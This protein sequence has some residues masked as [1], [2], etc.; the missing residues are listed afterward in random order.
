LNEAARP[1]IAPSPWRV[2]HFDAIDST[3]E[4]ARR[5]AVT[6][7]PGRLWIVADEQSAGRGRRG[8]IWL[9][10]RGNLYASAVLIDPCAPPIAAQLGFVAG[11][12]LA[13]AVKDLGAAVRLK[14]PND[15][16]SNGA[17]C[18][19]LLVEGISLAEK[20]IACVV[21]IGVNC[22][23]APDGA[24]YPTT[25]LAD[26]RGNPVDRRELFTRL[27]IRF[28]EALELWLG[29]AGFEAIRLL[30]LAYAGPVGERIRIENAAGRREGSF[31]GLDRD[32]R[33]LF[34]GE[35]GTEAVESADLWILPA[36]DGSPVGVSSA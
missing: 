20:R 29:G 11:V 4:E 10:P 23:S 34:R 28:D 18:A 30:W 3:S 25:R 27:A 32:G 22:E 7:D 26:G 21:G 9:S 8:R 24:G 1:F 17:K 14:W 35:R 13:R 15:L 16:V 19:G 6:G 33:L 36:S 2:V 5:C 31:E 12:A